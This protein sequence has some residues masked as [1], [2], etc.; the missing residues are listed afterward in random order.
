[1][2]ILDHLEVIMQ[3]LNYRFPGDSRRQC[4]DGGED[5]SFRHA[6]C[7]GGGIGAALGLT[8]NHERVA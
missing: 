7:G 8:E 2:S 3:S 4:R 5:S 1:M 6:D